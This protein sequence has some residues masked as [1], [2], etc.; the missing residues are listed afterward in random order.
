MGKTSS[1]GFALMKYAKP[2]QP[3]GLKAENPVAKIYQW[4]AMYW[5]SRLGV[6]QKT[7]NLTLQKTTLLKHQ[8]N[9]LDKNEFNRRQKIKIKNQPFRT[10][11][12]KTL[13]EINMITEEWETCNMDLVALQ[14]TRW[15]WHNKLDS[16][17]YTMANSMVIDSNSY[18]MD[19]QFYAM[20]VMI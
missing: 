8:Q 5:S 4:I 14:E 19:S 3:I 12:T 10:W 20:A 1:I 11:T 7:N 15:S 9:A 17:S 18:T 13:A 6:H 2:R 16:N